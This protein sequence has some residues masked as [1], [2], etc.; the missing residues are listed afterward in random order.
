MATATPQ[1]RCD[2]G[3]VQ[4][5]ATTPNNLANYQWQ[6]QS[7]VTSPQ[8]QNTSATI[9]Q[10][11]IFTVTATDPQTGCTYSD[12][13]KVTVNANPPI[14][15]S[16]PMVI[17]QGGQVQLTASGGVQYQWQ[18]AGSLSCTSCQAPTASPIATTT[19]TVTGT[20]PYGCTAIDTHR[21]EVRSQA[22]LIVSKDTT[23]C[24][25]TLVQLHATGGDTL[26]W[27]P[28][29]RISCTDCPDPIADPWGTVT[30][31]VTTTIA[32]GCSDTAEVTVTVLP[33]PGDPVAGFYFDICL[34]DTLQLHAS[35]AITYDWTPKTNII[36]DQAADPQVFPPDTTTYIVSTT[37]GPDNCPWQDS[38]V[39]R[40]NQGSGTLPND[41]AICTGQS[42]T[43]TASGYQTYQW[44][45]SGH[46]ALH[47]LQPGHHQ[48]NH[49][50]GV[51]ADGHQRAGVRCHQN[52]HGDGQSIAQPHSHWTRYFV[53]RYNRYP[54]GHRRTQRHLPVATASTG[55]QSPITNHARHTHPDH[56]LH[57]YRHRCQ[58]LHGP[59]NKRGG[60][61]PGTR[62][63][64]FQ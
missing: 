50:H 22:S 24:F 23:I 64:N 52:H 55:H 19:Y 44:Q 61:S 2:S 34:G 31:T 29:Y 3:L 13:T 32:G 36:G 8:S 14:L 60:S 18:P 49:D 43:L 9:T 35:G 56:G 39:V 53:C 46:I 38:V 47:Q 4:L 54:H 5:Q 57:G 41:T 26:R 1:G 30:Y 17:C 51:H 6:P 48:P 27:T 59:G 40:V 45:S 10:T 20:D 62:H 37:Y 25:A 21:V 7:L 28:N 11:T 42:A 58:R 16:G 15:I 33:P 12:T 63:Y